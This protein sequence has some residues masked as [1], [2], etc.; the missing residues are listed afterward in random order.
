MAVGQ[1]STVNLPS[2]VALSVGKARKNGA[3]PPNVLHFIGF[4]YCL[5]SFPFL[6][7]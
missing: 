5:L 6:R 7:V 4:K 3:P 2:F 1:G